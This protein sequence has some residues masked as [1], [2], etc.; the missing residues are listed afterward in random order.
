MEQIEMRVL[1]NLTAVA[2]AAV[3]VMAA[4]PAMA[5]ADP[6]HRTWLDYG[7]YLGDYYGDYETPAVAEVSGTITMT[8]P[9]TQQSCNVTG[10]IELWNEWP[11]GSPGPTTE[12]PARNKITSLQTAGAQ[13]CTGLNACPSPQSPMTF[14]DLPWSGKTEASG[15][16]TVSSYNDVDI[17]WCTG[18]YPYGAE[19]TLRFQPHDDGLCI[20]RFDVYMQSIM[21]LYPYW[22]P[23]GS[24]QIN[25]IEGLDPSAD[26]LMVE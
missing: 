8:M 18:T 2:I 7:M 19:G 10:E 25:N 14:N 22:T 5:S 3:A 9:W 16:G 23:S 13:A 4:L 21:D 15:S 26:C 24:L 20:D 12:T 11:N 17:D 1:R 6:S